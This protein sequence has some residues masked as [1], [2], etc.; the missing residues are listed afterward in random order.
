MD[1][2]EVYAEIKRLHKKGV[3]ISTIAKIVGLS[4]N[5]VYSYLAKPPEEMAVW[6][7]A[8]KSRTKKLDPYK[9]DILTWLQEHPDMSSAQVQDC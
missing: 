3:K 6:M 4:R 2:W 7:A 1:K 9:Q 8:S 5:T